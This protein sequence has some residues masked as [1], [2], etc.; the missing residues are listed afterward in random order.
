MRSLLTQGD[1]YVEFLEQL[2]GAVRIPR[3]LEQGVDTNEDIGTDFA[4]LGWTKAQLE[5]GG[6]IVSNFLDPEW[7]HCDHV[8]HIHGVRLRASRDVFKRRPKCP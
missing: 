2:Q 1:C 8:A 6:I 4:R 3:Y 5:G 7:V